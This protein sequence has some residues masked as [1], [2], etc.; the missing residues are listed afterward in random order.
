MT[1]RM[2]LLCVP[3]KGELPSLGTACPQTHKHAGEPFPGV[4]SGEGLASNLGPQSWGPPS[5]KCPLTYSAWKG[6]SPHL[7]GLEDGR[8]PTPVITAAAYLTGPS[9]YINLSQHMIFPMVS[10]TG[11]PRA[12][13]RLEGLL[14]QPHPSEPPSEH[15][16]VLRIWLPKHLL[17]EHP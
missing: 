2:L 15:L 7:K 9:T 3:T 12:F 17:S 4:S 8:K 1:P 6:S 16:L 10:P 14:L 13:V 5:G 11:I